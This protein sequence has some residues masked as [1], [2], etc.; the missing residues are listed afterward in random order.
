MKVETI[1]NKDLRQYSILPIR[2]V[3]D[4]EINRTAALAVLAVICS[5]TDELGR[6]DSAPLDFGCDICEYPLHC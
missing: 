6:T 1:R 2:A 5:Y 3:Q 4:P